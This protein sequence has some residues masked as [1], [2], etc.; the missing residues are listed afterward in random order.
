MK[1]YGC[2]KRTATCHIKCPDYLE[3][4]QKR[5]KILEER[6]RQAEYNDGVFQRYLRRIK[7]AGK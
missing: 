5:D 3:F 1:C 4:R 6:L 7:R 2:E